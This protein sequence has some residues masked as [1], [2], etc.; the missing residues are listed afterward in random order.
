VSLLIREHHLAGFGRA[1]RVGRVGRFGRFGRAGRAA[2][3]FVFGV[4]RTFYI[5][6][7]Y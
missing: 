7:L 5:L 6:H 1:G 2:D 3:C 4:V